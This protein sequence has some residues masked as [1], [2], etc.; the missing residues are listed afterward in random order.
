MRHGHKSRETSLAGSLKA[1]FMLRCIPRPQAY[2]HFVE[3]LKTGAQGLM[4][5]KRF[6]QHSAPD[7]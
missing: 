7:V 5:R 3:E 6:Q 2:T 1:A 4:E